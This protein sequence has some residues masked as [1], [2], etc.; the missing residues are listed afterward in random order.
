MPSPNITAEEYQTRFGFAPEQ[1]DLDRVNCE[2][3]GKIGHSMCGICELH[4][5]PRFT[6]GKC[7]AR[8]ADH[9]TR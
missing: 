4:N 2:K 8:G 5:C 1:D 9:G 7:F 3:A 6:C